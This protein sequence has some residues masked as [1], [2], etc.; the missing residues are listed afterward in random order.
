[1]EFSKYT[2]GFKL[3]NV[4]ATIPKPEQLDIN[5]WDIKVDPKLNSVDITT[6]K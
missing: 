3:T 5:N 2:I 1:M 6:K 4:K